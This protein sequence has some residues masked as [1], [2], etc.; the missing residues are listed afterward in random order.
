MLLSVVRLIIDETPRLPQRILSVSG[1]VLMLHFCKDNHYHSS[2]CCY[3]ANEH[4]DSNA[5]I[6]NLWKRARSKSIH[7]SSSVGNLK[8]KMATDSLHV[9]IT[10]GEVLRFCEACMQ[11]VG[12][13]KDHGRQLSEVLLAADYRGHFSHGLNRLREY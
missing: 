2:G 13:S 10:T 8:R 4:F 12:A 6:P 1:S 11:A 5:P 9:K 3:R 7:A